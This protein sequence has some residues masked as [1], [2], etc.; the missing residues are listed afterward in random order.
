MGLTGVPTATG[1]NLYFG[2][3]GVDTT[4]RQEVIAIFDQSRERF[5]EYDLTRLVQNLRQTERPLVGVLS[6]LP[7]A[8]GPGGM[9]AAMQ[10]QSQP[11]AI[12]EQ[13]NES[14]DV[15]NIAPDFQDLDP[16][17][18]VLVTPE[19]IEVDKTGAYELQPEATYKKASLR[20]SSG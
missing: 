3:V 8:F 2:L 17:L 10:G 14:F 12:W 9:Q 5:L 13:L 19:G 11:F 18:D 1:D 4:D 15:T 20:A 16:E 6:S 7:L